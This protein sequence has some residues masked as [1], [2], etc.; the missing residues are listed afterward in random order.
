MNHAAGDSPIRRVHNNTE[1]SGGFRARINLI[2]V[3]RVI[4]GGDS[5]TGAIARCG[6]V[7][8]VSSRSSAP[9]LQW[10]VPPVHLYTC[11]YQG[12]GIGGLIFRPPLPPAL[13]ALLLGQAG[14]VPRA[15]ALSL[16][17]LDPKVIPFFVTLDHIL[18]GPV[19]VLDT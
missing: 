11:P 3:Y 2:A 17:S 13:L 12:E 1:I 6:A 19:Q 16:A 15:A 5:Q 8:S 10:V 9:P 18:G 4:A 14:T 7:A